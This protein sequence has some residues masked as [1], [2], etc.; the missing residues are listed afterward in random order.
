MKQHFF[1]FCLSFLLVGA[2]M[3]SADSQDIGRPGPMVEI[4]AT[5]FEFR[6]DT[7]TQ[8]GIFYQFN[9]NETQD[10]IRNSDVF[11]PGTQNPQTDSPIPA[12]DLTGQFAQIDYGDID[13][14]VKAALQEGWGTVISNQNVMTTEGHQANIHLG[15]RIPFTDYTIQGNKAKL[16]VQ[17][18]KAGI[19]LDAVPYILYGDKIL[20]DL[21]ISSND[22]VRFEI[23][24]RGEG[25]RYELPIISTRSVR[26]VVIL[27]AGERLYIGGLWSSSDGDT[28]RKVPVLGDIPGIGFFFRGFNKRAEKAETLFQIIPNIVQPGVGGIQANLS[29]LNGILEDNS[30]EGGLIQQ[31]STLRS[32]Q[33]SSEPPP[34]VPEN[35]EEM[36]QRPEVIE[37]TPETEE[38]PAGGDDSGK[39]MPEIEEEAEPEDPEPRKRNSKGRIIGE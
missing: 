29:S 20:L 37:I 39:A 13:F 11:L 4:S 24:E 1:S 30:L 5:I 35:L 17:H 14:N 8:F 18:K 22:V 32:F 28:V 3:E 9:E 23:F 31:D 15:E 6:Y 7:E 10:A 25:I 12:L 26:T 27:P 38:P 19:S 21:Q 33:R 36:E 2:V 34:F 16:N